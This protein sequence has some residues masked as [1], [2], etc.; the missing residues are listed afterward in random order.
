MAGIYKAGAVFLRE[1]P[2]G[3]EVLLVRPKPKNEGE[4]APWV[5][6]RGSRRYQDSGGDWHDVRTADDR[7]LVERHHLRMEPLEETLLREA[8]EESG[9]DAKLLRS[10]HLRLYRL[11]TRAMP[12]GPE[13]E[14]LA[15]EWYVGLVKKDSHDV[16]D[17][18][19]FG[20][21]PPDA[22][23][24]PQW[25]PVARLHDVQD[26]SQKYI[27]VVEAAASKFQAGELDPF[28]FSGGKGSKARS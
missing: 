13:K 24:F 8:E 14:S 22:S 21:M 19:I 12:V 7:K 28:M 11:G 23:E 5:L 3:L 10:N 9:I 25:K 18:Q 27:A 16:V 20:K 17:A 2:Q 15:I 4:Q 26:L 6:P 1:G